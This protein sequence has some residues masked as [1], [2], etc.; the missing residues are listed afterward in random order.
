MKAILKY[1]AMAAIAMTA[2]TACN[3][4]AEE[5]LQSAKQPIQFNMNV[6]GSRTVTA[7]DAART[8]T[9]TDG[10]AV[11]IFVYKHGTSDLVKANAKYVLGGET[12]TAADENSK[13]YADEAY[14]FYAYYPYDAAN[15]DPK[16]V[17]MTAL[18]DQTSADSYG[19][20]DFLSAKNVSVAAGATNVPLAFSH[21]FSMVE[22]KI[23]GDKV[24]QKPVKVTLNNV[25]LATEVDI[26][27]DAPAAA[28][29]ADA[30][31]GTVN[32]YYLE[33]TQDADKA[34]F[35]FRA[36]VP[37]QEVAA[38]TSLVSV[39]NPTGDSKTY[40]MKYSA[41][42]T[43][44]ANK[45]RQLI[46]TIAEA[47][48]AELTIPATDF[49]FNP[50]GTSGEIS[51]EGG[52]ENPSP[53]PEEPTTVT[54][55]APELTTST[56]VKALDPFATNKPATGD[57]DFWFTRFQTTDAPTYALVEEDGVTAIKM[58]MGANS[59]NGWNKNSVGFHSTATLER[60]TYKLT[61][62]AQSPDAVAEDK[63]NNVAEVVVGGGFLIRTADDKTPF[64]MVTNDGKEKT[65]HTFSLKNKK[66]NDGSI[67]IDFTKKSTANPSSTA[68]AAGTLAG[69]TDTT[70]DDVKGIN[71]YF[72]TNK[73][74]SSILFRN[75]KLEKVTE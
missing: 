54:T 25:K 31:V 73:K 9:W 43:Y 67:L 29:T 75:I 36:V 14:D 22:V 6:N 5:A 39:E 35:V 64:R 34:P 15:T 46:V 61:Y 44:E 8:T 3:N 26:T 19:K 28:L 7:T 16:K 21:L 20:S 45:C 59:V 38:E 11:G 51:G 65:H 1:F 41:A 12:W 24:S 68:V 18:A 2:M 56:S 33:K 13:I 71:I 30:A 10:D 60:A 42:V 27:A 17:S 58:T 52:E 57:A 49:T 47:A 50:W 53:T 62:Q 4:E 32:M 48:K 72:Y 23:Q 37:A 40:S 70:E 66:W 69:L 74:G 55:L 63:D